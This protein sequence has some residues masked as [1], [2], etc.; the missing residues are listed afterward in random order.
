MDEQKPEGTLPS[1]NLSFPFIPVVSSFIFQGSDGKKYELKTIKIK[2][3][4]GHCFQ[5]YVD[6]VRIYEKILMWNIPPDF[7]AASEFLNIYFNSKS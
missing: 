5:I 7:Q 3:A 1:E 6:Q 4:D 2:D